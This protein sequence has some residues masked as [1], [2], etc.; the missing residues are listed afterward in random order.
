MLWSAAQRKAG[1]RVSTNVMMRDLDI[2]CPHSAMDGRRCFGAQ[3]AVDTTM[4]SSLHRDGTAKRGTAI[5]GGAVLQ[6]EWGR[7]TRTFGRIGN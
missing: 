7:R 1:G 3:L 5:R 4:V 2:T 6:V